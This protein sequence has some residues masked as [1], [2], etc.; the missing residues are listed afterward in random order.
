MPDNEEK[1]ESLFDK[2]GDFL[3]KPLIGG[4]KDKD[5]DKEDSD[6]SG[7][8]TAQTQGKTQGFQTPSSGSYTPPASTHTTPST[9]APSA[10]IAP[11][12]TTPSTPAPSAPIAPAHTTPGFQTPASG[13][14]T[15]PTPAAPSVSDQRI[16]EL[17]ERLHKA[18]DELKHHEADQHPSHVMASPAQRTYRVVKGDTM[19]KI[20]RHFYGNA[21]EWHKIY[22]ANRDKIKNPDL[23][24]PDQEFV[25]P[26]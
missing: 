24:Y 6:K 12:H 7:A 17:E 13:S 20:A 18:E 1:H 19:G 25:I 26:E 2:I 4:H 11:A 16:K 14:Y 8:A 15:P 5:E 23:I 10:P 22:E 21:A 3:N 9:P